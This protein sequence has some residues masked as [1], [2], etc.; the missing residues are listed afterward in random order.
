MLYFYRF[1][2]L[3]ATFALSANALA[4]FT[5]PT[6][7][8]KWPSQYVRTDQANLRVFV[9]GN[10]P[11]VVLIPSYGRDGGDDYN[12]F[13]NVLVDAGYL[14]LRPQPRGVL[15]STGPM[16]N[17]SLYDLAA[18]IA[19]VIDTLAG[20][21]AIVIGHAFGTFMAKVCSVLYPEKIPA[22]VVAAPGGVTIPAN[23]ASMPFIAG[24]TSLPLSQRLSA[25]QTAFF[26]PG[27]DPHIWLDGW[28]PET[29]AM[30]RAAIEAYGS[31]VPHWGGANTTQIL[32]IIPDADPFQPEDEW[33]ITSTWYSDRATS[34]VINDAS[35]A[36]FPEQ[37]QAVV[38]AVLPFLK[39]QIATS[40][41]SLGKV[42]IEW[43]IVF[44]TLFV[45]LFP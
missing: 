16:T 38:N 27:H 24:N 30:E 2:L 26:A 3:T 34:I 1:L 33:N 11:A 13:T 8:Y 36:L 37:G 25:L 20:G 31:L 7:S 9:Q 10:G 4:N 32:E 45:Y 44:C 28:Y 18:D 14:V 15:G 43:L 19:Q 17:A 21:R 12:Y 42:V 6:E 23:I 41:Y 5:Q 40:Y 35:H 29:L 22:I 39:L